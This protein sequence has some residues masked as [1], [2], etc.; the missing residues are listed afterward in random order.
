MSAIPTHISKH[1]NSLARNIA[2][3][4]L[5]Q[6][7]CEKLFYYSEPHF[8]HFVRSFEIS[9]KTSQLAVPLVEGSL[10][11]AQEIDTMI[12]NHSDN[13]SIDRL[14]KT[15]LCTMKIACYEILYTDTP[16]KVIIDEAIELAKLYGSSKSASFVNGVLEQIMIQKGKLIKEAKIDHGLLASQ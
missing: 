4:F 7:M 13:W 12:Q 5:Y 15:D 11:H 9:S 16:P 6:C 1:P 3:Q 2:V 14:M 8:N 10:N